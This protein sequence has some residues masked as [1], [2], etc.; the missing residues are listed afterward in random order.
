MGRTA[1][2]FHAAPRAAQSPFRQNGFR[3]KV[4]RPCRP[5]PGAGP[6]RDPSLSEREPFEA[7]ILASVR[8]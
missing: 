1:Y 8:P 3:P 4:G 6:V 5:Q 7:L 2:L